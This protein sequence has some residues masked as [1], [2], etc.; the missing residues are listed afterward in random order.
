[1]L[2][3]VF[4]LGLIFNCNFTENPTTE[5]GGFSRNCVNFFALAII[6]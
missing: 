3:T 2:N 5:A 1:M 4:L 6:F